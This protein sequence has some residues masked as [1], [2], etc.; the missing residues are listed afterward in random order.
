MK[1]FQKLRLH[2]GDNFLVSTTMIED[3]KFQYLL[4]YVKPNT[5]ARD[6]VKS[7]PPSKEND[8]KMIEHL[9]SRFGRADLLIE[10]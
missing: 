2:F 5:K 3:D 9:K 7:F 1:L 8:L 10:I 4:T 6:I